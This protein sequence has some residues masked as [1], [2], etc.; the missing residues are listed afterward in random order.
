MIL[1]DSSVWI[2]FFHRRPGEAGRELRRL[3]TE[4][5]PLALTGIVVL[6][7]LQGLTREVEGVEAYLA[8]WDLLEPRGMETYRRAAALF[9]QARGK[10]I[11]LTT[12]DSL[13]ATL[14][15]ENGAILF[16]LDRDFTR[17]A[18]FTA[19]RLYRPS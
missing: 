5:E 9:R 11:E 10:G 18:Q 16:T 15:L 2:D 14:A 4:A 17:I 6:E 8:Q 19:L 1:V 3:I 13:I 12:I 7:V